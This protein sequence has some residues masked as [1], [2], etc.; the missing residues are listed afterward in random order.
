MPFEIPDDDE[1]GAAGMAAVKNRY[2]A[3]GSAETGSVFFIKIY[4]SIKMIMETPYGKILMCTQ[5]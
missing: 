1:S 3:G 5:S 2:S 4:T